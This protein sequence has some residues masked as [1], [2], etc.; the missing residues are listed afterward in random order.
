[1]GVPWRTLGRASQQLGLLRRPARCQAAPRQRSPAPQ[2]SQWIPGGQRWP[3]E[4]N[5]Q[6]TAC[7][8]PRCGPTKPGKPRLRSPSWSSLASSG[9][10]VHAPHQRSPHRRMRDITTASGFR[11]PSSRIKEF[12]PPSMPITS[13]AVFLSS[14]RSAACVRSSSLFL[15]MK[16]FRSRRQSPE[17]PEVPSAPVPALPGEA[18]PSL[19]LS[20]PPPPPRCRC[21]SRSRSRSRS[22]CRRLCERWP[23]WPLCRWRRRWWRLRLRVRLRL[24]GSSSE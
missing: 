4:Q 17:P 3:H 22:R 16:S 6:G 13:L 20:W 21:R 15:R 10:P 23:P 11:T 1:M 8:M 2:T 24:S 12:L 9:L 5:A 7:P 14:P 19:R 18:A